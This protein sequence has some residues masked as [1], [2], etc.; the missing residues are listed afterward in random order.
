MLSGSDNNVK[1][2]TGTHLTTMSSHGK[3]LHVPVSVPKLGEEKRRAGAG[4]TG[5]RTMYKVCAAADMSKSLESS[6]ETPPSS[7]N[8][9]IYSNVTTLTLTSRPVQVRLRPRS[10]FKQFANMAVRTL[11]SLRL[12][13]Q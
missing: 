8:L 7:N 12:L 11:P 4:T 10:N 5:N 3:W 9:M 13:Q 6:N 2:R 1:S